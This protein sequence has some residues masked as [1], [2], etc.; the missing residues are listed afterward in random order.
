MDCGRDLTGGGR[1]GCCCMPGVEIGVWDGSGGRGPR[2][3]PPLPAM[4]LPKEVCDDECRGGGGGPS[5]IGGKT[6]TP[7][8]PASPL[9]GRAGGI[10]VVVM[11]SE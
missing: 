8:L 5:F 9:V 7:T 4:P 10:G 6:G 2:A 11:C 1:G 3:T